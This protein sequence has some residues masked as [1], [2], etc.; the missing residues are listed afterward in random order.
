MYKFYL[1]IWSAWALR[2]TIE[3]ILFALFLSLVITLFFYMQKGTPPLTSAVQSAL[4]V[5]FKFWFTLSWSLGL[6]IALFRSVKYF[7]YRCHDGYML[8]LHA[9][10][11]TKKIFPIGYGD[12]LKVWRKWFLLLIWMSALVTLFASL[13]LYFT[14]LER[15][16]FAWFNLVSLY[17]I[18]LISGF[19]AF[20]LMVARCKKTRIERC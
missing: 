5:I 3:S 17:C 20:I 13:F 10:D 1:K 2:V 18:V 11:S 4:F 7:F 15:S 16:F 9:C 6:L 12:L 14:S 8:V 19:A